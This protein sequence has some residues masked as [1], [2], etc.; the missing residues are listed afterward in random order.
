MTTIGE[1]IEI[2]KHLVELIKQFFALVSK[3]DSGKEENDG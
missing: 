3:Y 1:F 2:M